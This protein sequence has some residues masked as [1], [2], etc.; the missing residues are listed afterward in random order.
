MG[1]RAT[2]R[3]NACDARNDR[4]TAR[5][6]R[7]IALSAVALV[8]SIPAHAIDGCQVLLCLASGNWRSIAQCVPPVQQALRDLARGKPFPRCAM[9]G[10]AN[11]AEHQWSSPPAFCPPQ[12]THLHDA[13]HGVPRF[14]CD[15]DGAVT[16]VVDGALWS[17]TWWNLY[18]DPVT[19]FSDVA[20]A[21]LGTW[22]GRFDA[23]YAVWQAAQNQP[24]VCQGC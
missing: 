16:V 24:P 17:R 4:T 10:S 3:S 5:S 1:N 23:D 7:A 2:L 22:D 9:S 18:S 6:Y 20:K 8:I 11:S 21:Q 12:Y 19:E 14:V 13:G 15:Y